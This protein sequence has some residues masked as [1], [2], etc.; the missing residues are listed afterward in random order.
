L[1]RND[2]GLYWRHRGD[3]WLLAEGKELLCCRGGQQALQ[4][5]LLQRHLLELL[6]LLQLLC[7]LQLLQC[8]QLVQLSC[9]H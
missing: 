5:L 6:N 4:L 3:L 7:L 8:Y 1:R 9:S 2:A